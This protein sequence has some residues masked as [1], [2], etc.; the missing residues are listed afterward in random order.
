MNN[1]IACLD[2]VKAAEQATVLAGEFIEY[3]TSMDYNSYFDAMPTQ[4]I[5]GAQQAEFVSF[6]SNAQKAAAQRLKQI[7]QLMPDEQMQAARSSLE[8]FK[9]V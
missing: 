6:S 1:A 9:P 4:S 3:V 5:S 8:A 7:L 2:D